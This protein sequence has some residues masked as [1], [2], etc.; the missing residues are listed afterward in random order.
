MGDLARAVTACCGGGRVRVN[1]PLRE[2]TSWRIGGPA[3]LMVEP[4]S[5]EGL[6]KFLAWAGEVGV[7]VTVMGRG[8]NLL[9]A[10]RGVSGLLIRLE[11]SMGQIGI[12]GRSILAGAGTPLS[13]LARTAAGRALTGLAFCAGIP[14]SVGGALVT[15]AGAHNHS[16]AELVREVTV[17]DR[18]GRLRVLRGPELKFG[19]RTSIFKEEF[20]V[21][22]QV[23]FELEEGDPGRIRREMAEYTA[24]RRQTQPLD[25]PS[26]GSVFKNPPGYYAGRL[27]EEAGAKGLSRG[28]ARVSLRHANFIVNT[29]GATAADVWGLIQ[30]VREMVWRRTGVELALEVQLAGDWGE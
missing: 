6:V 3:Q 23:G 10:D 29:G 16:L 15:N 4:A 14:G 19:Y 24:L 9:V 13:G 25:Y 18:A 2:Y 26:A 21:A 1:V 28:G 30:T 7:P 11:K 27:I 22:A 17:V 8:T 12:Q 20:L 5:V